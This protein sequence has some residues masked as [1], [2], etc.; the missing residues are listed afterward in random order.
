ME[1]AGKNVEGTPVVAQEFEGGQD[2]AGTSAP[3]SD[4]TSPRGR[5]V[6]LVPS[7]NEYDLDATIDVVGKPQFEIGDVVM[8]F[9]INHPHPSAST[10]AS[11]PQKSIVPQML[12]MTSA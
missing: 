4:P 7:D 1:L 6:D 10:M 3:D 8:L 12:K 9:D 11:S 2:H 5:D